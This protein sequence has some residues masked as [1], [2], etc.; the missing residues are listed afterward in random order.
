MNKSLNK[1]DLAISFIKSGLAEK[2]VCTNE[3]WE[4]F[5]EF[6]YDCDRLPNDVYF[7]DV[8]GATEYFRLKPLELEDATLQRYLLSQQLNQ[9]EIVSNM[10]DTLSTIKSCV[11]FFAIITIINLILSVITMMNIMGKVLLY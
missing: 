4:E 7:Q 2:I 11:V 8:D 3:E 9:A 10:S 1:N 6:G 5:I